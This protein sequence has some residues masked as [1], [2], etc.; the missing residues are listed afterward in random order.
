VTFGLKAAQWLAGI[1]DAR[2]DLEQV[3]DDVLALQFGGAVG[4]LAALGDRG[5]DL[6]RALAEGLDLPATPLP[7]HTNRFRPARLAC[8][9]GIA[10]GTMGMVARDLVLLAQTEVAEV[11]EGG[12]EGRGGSSAMPHKHNPVGAIAI[13]ACAGQGPGLVAT[14][15][16]AMPQEHERGA[17]GWQAEWEPLR[18][19][20]RLTGSAAAALAETLA[21]LRLDPEKMRSDLSLT[22]AS[23][24]SESVVTALSPALGGSQAQTLVRR[25][26]EQATSTG[27]ELG[28]VLTEDP[29]VAA[30]IGADGLRRALDP[31]RYLGATDELIERAL[32]AH[33]NR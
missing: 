14:V 16:A 4:T 7:W 18:T 6:V 19:L 13:L 32:A 17:G 31:E 24:M 15:L 33:A 21:Q 20:L 23:I 27:R 12:P 29:E 10:L 30:A 8:A 22:G 3:R 28:E 2:R 1:E 25:A 5:P 26:A 9:L 11:A